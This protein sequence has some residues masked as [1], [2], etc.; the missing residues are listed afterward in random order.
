MNRE[1]ASNRAAFIIHQIK[2]LISN[3][4]RYE[5]LQI[6]QSETSFR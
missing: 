2:F 4:N 5:F 3:F 6:S 1:E